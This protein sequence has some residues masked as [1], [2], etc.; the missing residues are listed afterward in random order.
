M[1]S[2]EHTHDS[3]DPKDILAVDDQTSRLYQLEDHVVEIRADAGHSELLID[4]QRMRYTVGVAGYRLVRA[5]YSPAQST[6]LD[7]AR[8]YLGAEAEPVALASSFDNSNELRPQDPPRAALDPQVSCGRKS[9][10]ALNVGERQILADALNAIFESGI[11]WDFADEHNE[12][13]FKIHRGPAFLPWHRHFLFRFEQ[14]LKRFDSRLS[15]P[16]WDWTSADS[17]DLEAEPWKSFFGGRANT[18]GKVQ[19]NTRRAQSGDDSSLP[20]LSAI[21]GLL[22]DDEYKRFRRIEGTHHSGPH[23]FVG[24]DMNT[25]LSPRDPLFYLHHCNVDRIWSFWQQNHSDVS[26]Y[27]TDEIG[28][29]EPDLYE[30]SI[31]P[32]NGS[33]AGGASPASMLDHT[34]LGYIYRKD[35]AFDNESLTRNQ[36][37]IVTTGDDTKRMKLFPQAM[38]FGEVPIGDIEG[39]LLVIKNTGTRPLH[40][41]V[42]GRRPEDSPISWCGFEGPLNPCR[43][44]GIM[45]QFRSVQLPEVRTELVVAGDARGCPIRVPIYGTGVQGQGL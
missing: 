37:P 9:F 40:I 36:L 17:R 28:I 15:L 23:V 18:G 24:G 1:D 14:Y 16:Y 45:I 35:L 7:L 10:T 21:V 39:R 38:A 33:M 42:A 6:L 31:V 41:S 44:R 34:T 19:W 32:I 20:S 11:A 4:G 26:Q 30:G 8:V 2:S 43:S 25:P 12:Y 27:S 5:A 22:Y 3:S 29:D 13:N